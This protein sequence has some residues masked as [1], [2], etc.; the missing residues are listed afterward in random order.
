MKII[1]I[2]AKTK[3]YSSR[4]I[5]SKLFEFL[6]EREFKILDHVSFWNSL[7]IFA[8]LGISILYSCFFL[9]I[10]QHNT[11]ENPEYWYELPLIVSFV[12]GPY[13]VLAYVQECYISFGLR[14][15]L[16]VRTATNLFLALSLGFSVP[17]CFTYLIW[18]VSLGFNH[19]VPFVVFCGY[20][21]QVLFSLILWFEFPYELRNDK[22]FRKRLK[23]YMLTNIWVIVIHLQYAG[24]STL[25][26]SL[27]TEL[28]WLLAI[29]IP[30][31]RKMNSHLYEKLAVQYAGK[32]NRMAMIRNS[33][34]I[35]IDYS[36]FIA[37]ILSSA[38]D[39]TLLIFLGIEFL[40][41]FRLCIKTLQMHRKIK[42]N[43]LGNQYL[44]NQINNNLQNLVIN[45][46]IEVIV[47]LAYFSTFYLSYVGPNST[48]LGG[49]RNSYWNYEKVENL[50]KIL[51]VGIEM[52]FID[53]SSL[54][55]CGA[56]LHKFSRINLFQ[57]FCKV[58]KQCWTI[59]T[60]LVSGAL[61]LV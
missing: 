14:S 29:I 26:T 40:L 13:S 53:F 23:M 25:F 7:Y 5:S 22:E 35:G 2:P 17:Y 37:I 20:P 48:I 42:T 41:N 49:V 44:K 9:L 50:E 51:T 47:P 31:S 32:G 39:I 60:I 43:I 57:E 45:E 24:F 46:M 15:F 34:S 10:P 59:M 61:V 54:I 30:I 1:K 58:I 18:T 4:Q 8:V 28:Q 11:I 52:F 36:L 19:P 12:L 27:P 56:I 6:L 55:I 38:S 33:I 21:M 3:D 16:T